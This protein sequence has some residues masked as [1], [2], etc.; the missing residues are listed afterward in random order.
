M[1]WTFELKQ[2][3]DGEGNLI[4]LFTVI[5]WN[6]DNPNTKYE[7]TITQKVKEVCYD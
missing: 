6:T 7:S 1:A 2:Q 3:E 4:P 5:Q